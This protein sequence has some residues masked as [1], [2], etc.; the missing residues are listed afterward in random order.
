MD[1]VLR[2]NCLIINIIFLELSVCC[3]IVCYKIAPGRKNL[4]WRSRCSREK[5]PFT[6]IN[7]SFQKLI[8]VKGQQ[9]AR[10]DENG[11]VTMGVIDFLLD[12][13]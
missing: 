6:R 4:T 3:V 13:E 12:W 9:K 7:D 8:L 10:T 5:R 11:Y 2:I 1:V